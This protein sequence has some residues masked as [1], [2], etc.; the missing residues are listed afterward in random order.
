MS[1]EES[2]SSVRPLAV[3]GSYAPSILYGA[4]EWR[5]EIDEGPWAHHHLPCYAFVSVHDGAHEFH[6][7]E[8]HVR[9]RT[10]D[11][12]LLTPDYPYRHRMAPNCRIRYLAFN[13]ISEPLNSRPPNNS[14]WPVDLDQVQPSCLA[15]WGC[16]LPTVVPAELKSQAIQAIED[17]CHL[18]WR[19]DHERFRA[20]HQ[21]AKLL[22]DLFESTV[23]DSVGY[24]GRW[25]PDDLLGPNV[26][27]SDDFLIS[28]LVALKGRLPPRSVA[29]WSEQVHVS[30]AYF[31]RRFA[32]V[33]GCSAGQF[34][35]DL[36]LRLA[37]DMLTNTDYTIEHLAW[38]AGFRSV[39]ALDHAFTAAFD[40][41]PGVYRRRHRRMV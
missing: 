28:A 34:L 17:M 2:V 25:Q 8:G 38:E 10:G 13:V 36:R 14:L 11:V 4:S 15:V 5:P 37:V 22:A 33:A 26:D 31:S 29:D 3:L 6:G 19:G 40:C 23:H 12:Y 41:P 24:E 32:R 20:N 1:N 18:W 39:S 35:R 16:Q 27:K 9:L 30:R 21:L 7:P